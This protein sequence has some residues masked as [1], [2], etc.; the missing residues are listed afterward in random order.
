MGHGGPPTKDSSNEHGKENR[1]T[2]TTS[3]VRATARAATRARRE[4]NMT[5]TLFLKQTRERLLKR[6]TF[7]RQTL[8]GDDRFSSAQD[9]TVGDEVDAALAGEHAEIRS[10]LAETE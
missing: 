9:D 4:T 10:Q 8:A 6:R 3:L 7:L 2:A 5:R 1:P